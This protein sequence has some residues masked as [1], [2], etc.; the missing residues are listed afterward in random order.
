VPE[1]AFAAVERGPGKVVAAFLEVADRF[2]L[3]AVRL[4]VDVVENVQRL[5]DPPVL[6]ERV[7]E[8]GRGAAR[9]EDPKR[10]VGG[11]RAGV[12]RDDQP[13][14]VGPVTVDAGEVELPA[15]G[16]VSAARSRRQG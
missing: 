7:A 2:D 11:D 15:G 1:L 9:R 5:E 13:L 8:L 12:D 4:V 14:D 3:A 6:G 10:V 16:L